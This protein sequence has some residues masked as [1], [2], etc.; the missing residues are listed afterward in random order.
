MLAQYLAAQGFSL[1]KKTS[2]EWSMPCPIC[3]GT[4][5][6]VIFADGGRNNQ[7]KYYC[8]GCGRHGDAV[9]WKVD[10]E[11]HSIADVLPKDRKTKDTWQE[12]KMPEPYDWEQFKRFSRSVIE[13]A[14]RHVHDVDAQ[15]FYRSRALSPD[16]V[17]RCGFGW[18]PRDIFFPA[19]DTG[20]RDGKSTCVPAGAVFPLGCDD[21]AIDGVLVRRADV[22]QWDRFGK[23]CQIPI[24]K[25]NF[26][27]LLGDDCQVTGRSLVVVE[28]V[29]D[30]ASVYQARGGLVA[31]MA[32]LGAS[33]RPTG[34]ALR[35]LEQAGK[36]LVCADSDSGGVNLCKTILHVRQDA[37]IWRP[38]GEGVKDVNDCLQKYGDAGT[39]LWLDMGCA[40]LIKEGEA[41]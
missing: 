33:K 18:C 40:E 2:N 21:G 39:G 32:L 1:K 14:R 17:E 38:K 41:F 35:W 11:G 37:L 30:A 6:M 23:W 9:S 24:G 36:I 13:A 8:R 3:G 25:S 5:R 26:S 4:D 15:A 27:F 34:R 22:R 29:L 7:G 20:R 19:R 31:S 12:K 16:T 28:S 10:I